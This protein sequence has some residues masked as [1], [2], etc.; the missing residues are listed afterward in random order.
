MAS[1]AKIEK[2]LKL[3]QE[4]NG[5]NPSILTIKKSVV[6][7]GG[8]IND[9]TVEYVTKN[10]NV[11]PKEINKVVTIAEWYG[12]NM[13]EKLNLDF[14]PQKIKVLKYLGETSSKYCLY[15]QYRQSVEPSI[16]YIPKEAILKDFLADDYNKIEVD[17]DRYD[18]LSNYQRVLLDHQKEAVKFLLSRKK[19]VLADEQGLGKTVELAVAAIEGNFDSILIICPA[20]LKEVWRRELLFYV[21]ER[22]IT[23]IE[24]FLD[25]TKPQLEEFLG[26]APGK[27]NMKRDELLEEAK[28]RGQWKFNRFVIINYDILDNFFQLKRTY[29]S[30]QFDNMLNNSPLLQFIYN[31]K[32]LIIVDEAHELSNSKS[33]RYKTIRGLI[34]KGN[35]HSV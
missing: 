12:E 29:T 1:V 10:I 18:R 22:D 6:V 2:T 14:V 20:S 23:I 21:P 8:A 5:N 19:C 31:K 3:L 17:F 13:K 24:S 15:I 7:M 26:Y 4:Y 32:G 27:S 33:I 34:N 35:P 25:K 30:E 11:Q 16:K 28:K 9:A